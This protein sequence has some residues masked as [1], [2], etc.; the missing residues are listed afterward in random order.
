MIFIRFYNSCSSNVD[1]S[2][3]IMEFFF[4]I[5]SSMMLPLDFLLKSLGMPDGFGLG[6]DRFFL[7]LYM[8]NS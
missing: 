4:F 6:L 5:D 7:N 2:I 3:Y 8:R 1:F